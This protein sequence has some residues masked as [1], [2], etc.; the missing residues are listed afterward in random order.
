MICVPSKKV[1]G[2]RIFCS[3]SGVLIA[4]SLASVLA[5][6]VI[7]TPSPYCAVIFTLLITLWLKLSISNTIMF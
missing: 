6:C 1:F 5:I 4:T 3:I 2:G 7:L